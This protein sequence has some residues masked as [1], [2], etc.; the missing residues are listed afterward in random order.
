MKRTL[1]ILLAA[2]MLLGTLGTFAVHAEET[3]KAPVVSDIFEDVPEGKWFTGGVQFCYTYGYMAGTADGVFSPNVALSR[4]M[5]VQILYKVDMATE[6][7]TTSY[8]T[9]VPDGKWYTCAV[10]WAYRNGFAAGVGNGIFK[11]S[12]NVSREQLAVFLRRYTEMRGYDVSASADITHYSDYPSVAAWSEDAL[13]WAVAEGLITGMSATI[14]SPK[15]GA[16]RAQTSIIL[17]AYLANH[18]I[19]WDL[20][21]ESVHRTCTVDGLTEFR[22]LNR[23]NLTMRVDYKAWHSYGEGVFTKQPTCTE[24]GERLLTCKFC[25]GAAKTETVKALGHTT[26]NGKCTRCGSEIRHIIDGQKYCGIYV[27]EPQETNVLKDS[28]NVLAW[29][30]RFEEPSEGKISMCLDS[31]KYTAFISVQPI[32]WDMKSVAS[33]AYD[34]QIIN[35]LK[36]LSS[37]DRINTELFIRFAHEMEMRP[38]YAKNWFPWQSYDAQTYV[39]AWRHV[40]TL[41]R[42]Y[43]PNVKWVWSPNRADGYTT[44]YYPG[45]EYVDYVSLTLNN[46]QNMYATFKDFYVTE[47]TKTA[48]EAYG[49]PIIFGELSEYNSDDN[50]R[51]QYL[52]SV[53]DFLGGY[54]KCVGA[55]FLNDDVSSGRRF[56]FTYRPAALNAFV[57]S[58]R[59]YI[60]S[61]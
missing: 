54:D 4:A 58:S 9:D 52:K 27:R 38:V 60:Q 16:T 22:A 46:L 47:G 10:E 29:F 11:P 2:L 44:A 40:V 50:V 61:K 34:S 32:N 26:E 15:T 3:Y 31:H 36:K 30:D 24:D 14:L 5:F 19:Q 48:L 39:N 6:K 41:G 35:Y 49:K 7:Y 23:E 28:V 43:A 18:G 33:G 51:A 13:S 25:G 20:G 12:A 59:K 56:N 53:F 57:E 17:R 42:Q 37:G 1:T 8:F 45:D 55:I 21:T